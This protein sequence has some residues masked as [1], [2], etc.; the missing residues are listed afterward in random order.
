MRILDHSE[1]DLQLLAEGGGGDGGGTAAAAPGVAAP[2][3][4]TG[5]S[6][7]L[8]NVVYGK[9]PEVSDAGTQKPEE[10]KPQLTP[11]D[12]KAEFKKLI[13][14]EYREEYGESVEQT[15]KA[16]PKSTKDKVDKYDALMP[17]LEM[18]AN[19]YGT[20]PDD[21][22]ALSKAIAEDDAFYEKEAF[23]KGVSVEQLKAYKKIE[24][25]NEALRRANEERD[26]REEGA[27][28]YSEWMRQAEDAKAVYPGLDLRSEVENPQFLRLL[29]AGID[30]KTAY[31]VIHQDEIVPAAMQYAAKA[32]EKHTADKI[33]ARGARPA[34]NGLGAAGAA[35]VKRDVSKFTDADLDEVLRRV[36]GG[37]KIVL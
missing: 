36:K 25:E 9:Q 17:T 3:I 11:E 27:R 33:A 8:A 24:R 2:D 28:Q 34:E 7:P 14:G 37:D 15:V 21:I 26:M 32:A 18:L 16:R 23:E 1:I 35:V 4:D 6:N 12:R 10:A 22:E 29:R 5:D 30:V 19:K 20:K 31:T 13:K